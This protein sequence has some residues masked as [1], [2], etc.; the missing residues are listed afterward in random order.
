MGSN[1]TLY[2][3]LIQWILVAIMALPGHTSLADNGTPSNPVGRQGNWTMIFK[4]EFNGSALDAKKWTTCYWWRMGQGCT[5][6]TNHELEWYRPNNV[7]LSQG[8]L[9]LQAE[10]QQI[11]AN[12]KVY[13]YTSGVVTT[14]PV[15]EKSA[16]VRF[17]LQYGY[18]EIRAKVPQGRGLWSA[19][20]LLPVNRQEKPEIDVMEIMGNEPKRMTMTLHYPSMGDDPGSIDRRWI[21]PDFSAG[22][23]TFGV[24]WEPDAV[25]WYVDGV[26]RWRVTDPTQ[27]PA[28]PMYL[29]LNLAVGGDWPGAPDESTPFPCSFNVDYV[30]VWSRTSSN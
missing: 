19:F 26:A 17:A 7:Q 29:L 16:S 24:D 12:G 25:V 8:A 14:G 30:R 18:V 3:H 10:R 15:S 28:Q 4:D 11:L 1:P 20:W 2:K 27:I 6:G 13:S 22:F 23:H 5:I 9:G 21:G